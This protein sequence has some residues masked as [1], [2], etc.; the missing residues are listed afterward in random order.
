M[1]IKTIA[2]PREHG[3]WAYVLEPVILGLL[4]AF[5]SKGLFLG[6]GALLA[7]LAHQPVRVF[8]ASQERIKK[9]ALLFVSLY[10]L[11][12]VTFFFLF[13]NNTSPSVYIPFL[14]AVL[15]MIFYLILELQ[16]QGKELLTRIMAP[17]AIDLMAVS[18][19]LVSGWRTEQA[20]AF[21][22][23][24]LSRSYPTTFYVRAKLRADSNHNIYAVQATLYHVI[25]LLLTAG[26]VYLRL[27]PYLSLL[28]VFILLARTVHGLYFSK[29]KM[30]PKQ[31][32]IREFVYGI[33]F[34][35]ISAA[36][37]ISHF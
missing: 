35:F 24:L 32:G 6:I 23:L 22:A 7:F 10:G 21:F 28:A 26:L 3:A 30:I 20:L 27:I 37:Y 15:L 36:G 2:L 29:I 34:V 1:Q 13:I 14:L 12:A 11:S 33:L 5:S 18:M 4:I 17:T 16:G 19:V 9:T 31:V 25:A 8:F